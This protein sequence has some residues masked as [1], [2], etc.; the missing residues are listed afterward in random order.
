MHSISHSLWYSSAALFYSLITHFCHRYLG[1][2]LFFCYNSRLFYS[3]QAQQ[4]NKTKPEK[5]HTTHKNAE[6]FLDLCTL[7]AKAVFILYSSF[8]RSYH[9]PL[10]LLF[11]SNF[12]I[13][14]GTEK[15]Q[16]KKREIEKKTIK[17]YFIFISVLCK[18]RECFVRRQAQPSKSFDTF[19]IQHQNDIIQDTKHIHCVCSNAFFFSLSLHI[20]FIC[21]GSFADATTKI[22]TH[23]L[24]VTILTMQKPFQANL[25]DIFDA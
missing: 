19:D 15:N 20:S 4:L 6:A 5:N 9:S 25:S 24:H 17:K 23:V 10:F 16:E 21:F 22:K 11:N 3:H 2:Y 7:T 14:S 12:S 13:Y 18:M 8:C 1:I